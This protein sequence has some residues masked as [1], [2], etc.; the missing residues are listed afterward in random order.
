M[1]PT[2]G[3]AAFRPAQ[4]NSRSCSERDA[5]HDA[6][7]HSARNLFDA[8]DQMVDLGRRSVELDDQQRLD[9]ERIAGMDE[10][11]DGRDRRTIHDLHAAGNDS[12][13]R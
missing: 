12:G 3:N 4:N 9:V 7:R 10:L 5:L 13:C 8:F 11:F 2:A 1:R 6:A